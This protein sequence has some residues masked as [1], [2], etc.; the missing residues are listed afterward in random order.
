M[1]RRKKMRRREAPAAHSL[2]EQAA[3]R[4]PLSSPRPSS[5][6]ILALEKDRETLKKQIQ[7]LSESVRDLP[8]GIE[9]APAEGSFLKDGKPIIAI[10]ING[11][12]TRVLLSDPVAYRKYEDS[13]RQI[14]QLQYDLSKIEFLLSPPKGR[15][16]EGI[17]DQALN[18]KLDVPELSTRQLAERHFPLYFPERAD[19]AIRMMDQGLR[20]ATRRATKQRAQSK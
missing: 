20:R 14:G 4:R 17:Y 12:P 15:P 10:L 1:Q 9:K 19:D 6:A 8:P 11:K 5:Q 18:E 2:K 3:H 16:R 7:S 13:Q